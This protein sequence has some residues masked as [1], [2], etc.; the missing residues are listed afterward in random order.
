MPELSQEV[1]VVPAAARSPRWRRRALAALLAVAL[2]YSVAPGAAADGPLPGS[3][4]ARIGVDIV[5]AVDVWQEYAYQVGVGNIIHSRPTN[6]VDDKV[7]RKSVDMVIERALLVRAAQARGLTFTDEERAQMR[8]THVERWKGEQSFQ[9]ALAMMN[10][11]ESYYLQR[12]GELQLARKLALAEVGDEKALAEAA[13]RDHYQQHL[14]KYLDAAGSVR[15]LRLPGGDAGRAQLRSL[16]QEAEKARSAGISYAEVVR[17]FSVAPGALQGGVIAAGGEEPHRRL[18]ADLKPC[19]FSHTVEDEQGLHIYVRDC[20]L[21][22]PF[23]TVSARVRR[24]VY[25][26]RL[27]QS[28]AACVGKARESTTIELLTGEPIGLLTVPVAH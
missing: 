7:L 13:V 24:D 5:P 14:G 6:I 3:G 21:P 28:Q 25:E 12:Y 22:L 17:T 8:A 15:Y 16:Y 19:R 18:A 11:S 23:E 2:V 9:T 26:L 27:Q 4:G 20:K 1:S 10:V